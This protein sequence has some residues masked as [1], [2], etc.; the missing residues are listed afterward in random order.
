MSRAARWSTLLPC[1]A[2]VAGVIACP[3]PGADAPRD[4]DGGRWSTRDDAVLRAGADGRATPFAEGFHGVRAVLPLDAHTAFILEPPNLV[5]AHDANGDGTA[6]ERTVVGSGLAGASSLTLASDGW[7]SIGGTR[8]R[9]RWDGRTLA[10]GPD[11]PES[12]PDVVATT[13][14]DLLALRDGEIRIWP[15]DP[16]RLPNG[17]L[18]DAQDLVVGCTAERGIAARVGTT[19]PATG[20]LAA[21]ETADGARL[22]RPERG[23][24]WT[25]DGTAAAA[26]AAAPRTALGLAAARFEDRLLTLEELLLRVGRSGVTDEFADSVRTLARAHVDPAV[27]RLALCALDR[28]GVLGAADIQAAAGDASPLVRRFVRSLGSSG[29]GSSL[30]ATLANPTAALGAVAAVDAA[31]DQLLVGEPDP[32]RVAEIADAAR[33]NPAL[34]LDRLLERRSDWRTAGSAQ[35]WWFESLLDRAIVAVGESDDEGAPRRLLE[36][37]A[38]RLASGDPAMGARLARAAFAGAKPNGRRHAIVR[39]DREP[40]GY[41]A[42]LASEAV[43]DLRPLD[44][45]MRWPGRSDVEAPSLATTPEETIA[46]GRQVYST[47]LTCHGPAGLGQDGVYPPLAGSPYVTGD[48][49]RFARIVLFG[50]KGRVTVGSKEVVG[51]MPRPAIESDEEIAAV[52]TYVRQAFGNAADPVPASVVRTVRERHAGR[53]EPFDVSELDAPAGGKA[54]P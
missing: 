47:C 31:L 52:M 37:A 54:R 32:A 20:E 49:E 9:Y 45:W 10:R 50:L 25:R 7:M 11:R 43:A 46:L 17:A 3:A 22:R 5:L 12:M 39:L 14:G 1:S 34:L 29:A 28:M 40:E 24:L 41:R 38:D 53:T 16:V 44:A 35:P 27:R 19:D 6:D 51:L 33:G 23:W 8:V 2:L 42:L 13:G 36:R 26:G 4:L 30:T 21:I 48:P 15:G 18:V